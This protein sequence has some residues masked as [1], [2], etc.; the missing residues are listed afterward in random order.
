MLI[1]LMAF[2]L[3]WFLK[4]GGVKHLKNEMSHHMLLFID[5]EMFCRV[6]V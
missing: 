5:V 1:S 4:K 6:Q 3:R 2:I